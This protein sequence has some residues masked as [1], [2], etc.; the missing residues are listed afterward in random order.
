L[1]KGFEMSEVWDKRFMELAT[2][3]GSWSKD[4]SRQVGCVIVGPNRE[5]RS[6]GYNGF[7]KK[8]DDTP[9]VRHSRPDKYYW[10]EHAERNAIYQAARVGIPLE[11][12]TMYLPWFPCVDCARAIVQTGLVRLVSA[13]PDLTDAQWGE[14]FSVAMTILK[15]AEIMLELFDLTSLRG[16]S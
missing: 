15:E 4:E 6:I 16:E 3:I 10:T 12:C 7:P 13:E 2:K 5:V 1:D 11:G 9:R 14:H 8:I